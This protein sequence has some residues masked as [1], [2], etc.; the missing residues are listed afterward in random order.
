MPAFDAIVVGGGPAGASCARFL[1]AQGL[2]VAVLDKAAFPRDKVCAGWVT[3]EVVATLALDLD[4]YAQ[5]R[6]LQP[7]RRFIT[8][9]IDGAEV[10]TVYDGIASYGI[11]RCEFDHYLLQRS[12]AE[13]FLDEAFKD[14]Q[15]DNKDWVIN[16]HLR[17]PLLIGAGGHFCPVARRLGANPGRSEPSIAAQELE[18][19]LP[20]DWTM[21][22]T[23]EGDR[24]ELFF[25]RDLTGYG[26]CFRKG[27]YLNIGL[28]REDNHQLAK[29]VRAFCE[30]LAAR[31]KIPV[32][33]E[34]HFKGHAY[35]LYHTGKRKLIDDGVLLIGDAAALAYGQSG[36]GIRP[37][38]ESAVFAAEIVTA[39][40]GDYSTAKLQP[41]EDRL[42]E[43]FGTRG[44][45]TPAAAWLPD[46][47]RRAIAHGLLGSRW[48][49][50]NVVLD[51][52]FLHRTQAALPAPVTSLRR[53]G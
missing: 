17:A 31:G 41:Y 8:G 9:V 25:C 18:F 42:A 4:D 52:W 39:A 28:G 15:R 13:L 36:E 16:G 1:S 50:R 45:E 10:E 23:I 33:P 12:G 27:D 43:R 47:L 40:A 38:I 48:F 49:S 46:G 11:R 14:A 37:A 34:E 29:Q 22:C 32:V 5:G 3:P 21:R 44:A 19:P 2:R 20:A 51:R 53:A 26:W 30:F 35:I 6:V 24:P 7:I